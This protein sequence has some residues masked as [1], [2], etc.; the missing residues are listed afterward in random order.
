MTQMTKFIAPELSFLDFAAEVL[1]QS[2]NTD[3][4][5][6]ERMKFIG[7][8]HNNIDNFI[9]NQYAALHRSLKVYKILGDQDKYQQSQCTI[10]NVDLKLSELAKTAQESYNNVCAALRDKKINIVED[11]STLEETEVS[12]LQQYFIDNIRQYIYPIILDK[13]SNVK[14]NDQSTY[15]VADLHIYDSVNMQALIKLPTNKVSRFVHIPLAYTG[16]DS[17]NIIW[18]DDIIR[19]NI[20]LIFEGF[21]FIKHQL[22]SLQ[23]LRESKLTFDNDLSGSLRNIRSDVQKRKYNN[24]IVRLHFDENMPDSVLDKVTDICDIEDAILSSSGKYL[25]LKDL[26]NFKVLNARI[27]TFPQLQQKL[28]HYNNDIF[29]TIRNHDRLL[30][31]PEYSFEI[32]LDLLRKA[33]IDTKVQSIK[34][35]MYRL[36]K[37]SQVVDALINAAQNGKKV[38]VYIEPTASFDEEANINWIRTLER[39]G[40]KVL[41]RLLGYKVHAK[42]LSISRIENGEIQYYTGIS[43]G[44]PNEMTTQCYSDLQLLT[45][46][47]AIG[48]DVNAIFDI[49]ANGQLA[50]EPNLSHIYLSPWSI[51]QNIDYFITQT[52]ESTKKSKNW[53]VLKANNLTDKSIAQRLCILKNEGVD[54]NLIIRGMNIIPEDIIPNKRIVG[55]FLE[56]IRIFA[57]KHGYSTQYFISSADLMARNFNNRIEV[58]VE[59]IEPELKQEIHEYLEKQLDKK[60]NS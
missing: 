58:M 14:L 48:S 47:R 8:F 3:Y 40:I 10:Y 23:L 31:Y 56:H 45:S 33:A 24:K 51:R 16:Y 12:Y 11:I 28:I 55:R 49:L 29:E 25:N 19:L 53:C 35:T 38:A 21:K 5:T 32:V 43:T 1:A 15:L 13:D 17:V 37:N 9:R 26:A 60:L 54:V 7:L 34:M 50:E 41:P 22:Y 30:W 39:Y 20:P 46:S 44:N 18:L 27:Q 57:F 42:L 6:V 36:A 52:R 59:I 2:D 4:P